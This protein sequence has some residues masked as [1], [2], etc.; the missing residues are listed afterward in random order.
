MEERVLLEYK[1]RVAYITLN[2]PQKR[3]ALNP[4]MVS[5]LMEAL[6]RVRTENQAKVLVL[7]ASG[8]AFCAG[9]DLEYL[10]SLQTN[11]YEE[12]LQ[13][14][15][16]LMTLFK[17]L[18]EFPLPV[19]AKVHG[20]A[21]A[22]GCGLATVCDF[23]FA[24]EAST[25]GYSEVNIGF[26]PAIVMV[27]LCRKIG[28]GK[29]RELLLT[30]NIVSASEA[31]SYGLIN[32]A[33]PAEVLDSEVDKLAQSLCKRSASDSMRLIKEMLFA[34][35]SD[36]NEALNFAAQCNA[37]ARSTKDCKKGIAAFLNKEKLTW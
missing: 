33:L 31:E 30:G 21:I 37:K 20:A 10:K 6:N 15:Q 24:S 4:E 34:M 12:N 14:S 23:S 8:P 28:E 36:Y 13:D 3:N 9:A 18:I 1:D 25:L 7:Q 35:P 5:G 16:N 32:R 26:V 2:R 11:S 17:T 22:G 19:I 27:F 29:A